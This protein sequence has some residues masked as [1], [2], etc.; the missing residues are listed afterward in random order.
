MSLKK[1]SFSIVA[2]LLLT[3]CGGAG[4]VV[5]TPSA[6][7]ISKL[8]IPTDCTKAGMSEA[9]SQI[10]SG[11][12]Y[13]PTK[14]Q[15]ASGTELADVLDNGGL[16]CSYGLQSAEIGITADWVDNSKGLFE[17]RVSGWLTE[18]Y[19]KTD[20]PGIANAEA[21]FL[22][23]KQSPKQE[24]HVW[25]LNVKYHG[26]WLQLRCTAFAQNL[27]AGLPLLS[28]MISA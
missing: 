10:V 14:W 4:K 7:P 11:A 22:L 17:N 3:G 18:G 1:I 2:V 16:A 27:E 25:I 20:L 26:A 12:K 6:S 19:V 9:L 24:F 21:Y 13:I 5:P 15:P 28:A 8:A 23:K